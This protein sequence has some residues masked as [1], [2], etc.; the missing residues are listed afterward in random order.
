MKNI[1]KQIAVAAAV[2]SMTGSAFAVATLRVSTDD[3]TW[4]TIADESGSDLATGTLGVVAYSSAFAGWTITISSGVT[5]PATGTP[6]DPQMHMNVVAVSSAAATLYVEWSDTDFTPEIA[7]SFALAFSGAVQGT[8]ANSA[9]AGGNTLFDKSNLLGSTSGGPGAY[10]SNQTAAGTIPTTD[11]YSLTL[12]TV[13]THT[14]AGSSSSDNDLKNV[15]DGGATVA[16]L[17]LAL[18]SL[19]FV[20]RSGKSG[21]A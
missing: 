15:P 3:A 19:C 20:A 17:G 4:T 21:K 9:Y 5:K 18:S 2:L 12:R 11:P 13:F 1:T 8:G 16:L 10:S 7:G 6:A 14:A